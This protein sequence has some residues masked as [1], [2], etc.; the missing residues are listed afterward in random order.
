MKWKAEYL[1]GIQKIDDEHDELL[2]LISNVES[3]LEMQLESAI[4][5]LVVLDLKRFATRHFDSEET[6]MR[7]YGYKDI[8]THA[9]AHLHFI[10]KLDEIDYHTLN[11]LAGRKQL[12]KYL[13]EWFVSHL[14]GADRE[15]GDFVLKIDPMLGR[16]LP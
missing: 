16:A 4:I 2:K 7:A 13:R 6:M 15:Y 8:A 1:L 11:G 9:R 12:L 3:A 14:N 5:H 10:K